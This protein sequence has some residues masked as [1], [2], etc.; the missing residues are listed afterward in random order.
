MKSICCSA[1]VKTIIA[2]E[3]T[4]YYMCTKCKRDCNVKTDSLLKAFEDDDI[5]QSPKKRIKQRMIQYQ[6]ENDDALHSPWI[7]AG[8]V[9][10]ALGAIVIVI[11]ILILI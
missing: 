5:I 3:G 1:P 8:R 10:I 2:D 9:C 7:D 6:Q 4:G 11:G